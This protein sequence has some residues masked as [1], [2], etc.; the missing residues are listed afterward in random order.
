MIPMLGSPGYLGALT[1]WVQCAKLLQS[2]PTLCDPM[3]CSQQDYSVY[4]IL[5]VRILEW[6][7]ISCSNESSWPVIKPKSSALTGGFFTTSTTWEAFNALT[8][9]FIINSHCWTCPLHGVNGKHNCNWYDWEILY[10]LHKKNSLMNSLLC[11]W[12]FR[13]LYFFQKFLG[14]Y[15][16]RIIV[17]SF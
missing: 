2:C 8:Y 1:T 15:A 10:M 4:G 7:A 6:V 17:F 3:D 12:G 14:F 11:N 5:Q 16:K 13:M 9:Y